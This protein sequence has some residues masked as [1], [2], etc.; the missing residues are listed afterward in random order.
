MQGVFQR[1]E[2]PTSQGLETAGDF[3][4]AGF[5]KHLEQVGQPVDSLKKGWNLF[6]LKKGNVKGGC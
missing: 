1:I 5:G 2:I 4:R 3:E 6:S